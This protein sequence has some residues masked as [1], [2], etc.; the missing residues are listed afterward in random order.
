MPSVGFEIATSAI[1]RPHTYALD[2]TATGITRS[3]H[4]T[5]SSHF[6]SQDPFS[7]SSTLILFSYIILDITLILQTKI[8]TYSISIMRATCPEK[9]KH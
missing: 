2:R 8:C 5:Y 6:P 3:F 9:W 1:E 4:E 7:L